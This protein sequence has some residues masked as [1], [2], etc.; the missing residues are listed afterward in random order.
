[1]LRLS[2]ELRC[3]RIF[4]HVR[5]G[6]NK[7]TLSSVVCRKKFCYLIRLL[8]SQQTFRALPI[9]APLSLRAS[10][11]VGALLILLDSGHRA[12]LSALDAPAVATSVVAALQ[13]YWGAG[14]TA[15]DAATGHGARPLSA[16]SGAD[17]G[18]KT[19]QEVRERIGFLYGIFEALEHDGASLLLV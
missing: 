11:L 8:P 15:P 14:G 5:Q 9:A 13:L 6:T 10:L 16:P 12:V 7:A 3:R 4:R 1:M 18:S 19:K 2:A 17:I